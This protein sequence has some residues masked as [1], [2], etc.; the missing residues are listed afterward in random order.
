MTDEDTIQIMTTIQRS[1]LVN[2]LSDALDDEQIVELIFLL[3]NKIAARS[4]VSTWDTHID[5]IMRLL[6][7]LAEEGLYAK[8]Y[9]IESGETFEVGEPGTDLYPE[10]KE[11]SSS[12]GVSARHA[13]LC[14]ICIMI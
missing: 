11:T 8:I 9:D 12:S 14:S 4:N 10:S 3:D 6:T 13:I 1:N 7:P 5:I 2:L